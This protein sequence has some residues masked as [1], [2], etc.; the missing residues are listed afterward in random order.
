[1]G[2]ANV[3]CCMQLLGGRTKPDGEGLV[4]SY[5]IKD[6]VITFQDADDA[7]RFAQQLEADGAGQVRPLLYCDG[8]SCSNAHGGT[9]AHVGEQAVGQLEAR[10]AAAVWCPMNARCTCL[11]AFSSQ[12]CLHCAQQLEADRAGQEHQS[13]LVPWSLASRRTDDTSLGH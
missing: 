12:S 10:E 11:T 3:L 9:V 5:Q 8:L 7:E 2:C 1:M 13:C 6:G 4:N